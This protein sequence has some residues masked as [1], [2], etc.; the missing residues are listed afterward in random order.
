MVARETHKLKFCFPSW[1]HSNRLD[2]FLPRRL[3]IKS[4][5]CLVWLHAL[6]PVGHLE[7]QFEH[8]SRRECQGL[9]LFIKGNAKMQSKRQF[10]K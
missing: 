8:I 3:I 9:W 4:D 6:L 2:A 10:Y 7:Y 5:E 1:C